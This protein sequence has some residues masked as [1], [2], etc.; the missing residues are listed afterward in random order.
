MLLGRECEKRRVDALV[1]AGRIGQSGVLVIT[2]EAGIGKTALLNYAVTRTEAMTVL[3]LTGAEAERD[4]PFAGLAQLLRLSAA[5]LDRLPE[6][7]AQALGVALALRSGRGA[8]RFAV[9]AGT[10]TLLTRMSEDRPL[11]LIVDDAHLVDRPSQEALAF[12]ARRLLADA[13]V[14]LISV[15]SDEPCLFAS[16]DLPQL[17]L[18][19]ID[20]DATKEL[21][22]LARR[23]P[24]APDLVKKVFSVTG[25][26]PLAIRDTPK[27]PSGCETCRPTRP[28]RCRRRSRSCTRDAPQGS[29]RRR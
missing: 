18:A 21:V 2:G 24:V 1:A 22:H 3:R 28:H 14:L 10:V 25:G 4:L 12:L 15:R 11:C 9:G 5:D 27:S 29:T 17:R 19:G 20:A 13:I 6:P 26:N 7:Q 23:T 16:P 8:D